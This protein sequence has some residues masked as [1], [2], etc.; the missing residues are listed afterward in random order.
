MRE[1]YGNNI[2][3]A[4]IV[5]AIHTFGDLIG[6][7]AHVH[8]IVSEGAFRQDGTFVSVADV[9]MAGCLEQWQEQVFELLLREEKINEEVVVSMRQWPHSGFS[10]D[11]PVRIGEKDPKGMQ[12]LISYIARCQFR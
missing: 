5:E 12:R 2:T 9:D 4:N 11:H 8:A 1:V 6:W 7:H 3:V 10:I